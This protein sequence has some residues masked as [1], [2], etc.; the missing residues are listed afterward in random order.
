[1]L[2]MVCAFLLVAAPL[3]VLFSGGP[4]FGS[5]RDP[6]GVVTGDDPGG[7]GRRR[8]YRE[9]RRGAEHHGHGLTRPR[10]LGS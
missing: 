4:G 1:M 5:T 7:T 9:G 2:S 8:R 10:R 6:D 3:A